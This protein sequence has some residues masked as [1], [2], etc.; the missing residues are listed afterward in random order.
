MENCIEHFQEPMVI[1]LDDDDDDDDDD[2]WDG[3]DGFHG[4]EHDER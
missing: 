4:F 2:G 3:L 1:Y